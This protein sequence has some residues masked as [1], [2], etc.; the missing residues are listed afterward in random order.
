MDCCLLFYFHVLE[1]GYLRRTLIRIPSC[2]KLS[3]VLQ[4]ARAEDEDTGPKL[5]KI[6]RTNCRRLCI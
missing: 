5:L 6:K 2:E 4:Y 1:G 3:R